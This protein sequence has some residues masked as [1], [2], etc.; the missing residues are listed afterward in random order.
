MRRLSMFVCLLVLI[1]LCAQSFG[2]NAGLT[3][4]PHPAPAQPADAL[5]PIPHPILSN[6]NVRR[7]IYHCTNKD[8]LIAAAYPTL[9]PA[10]RAALLLDSF[11]PPDS[12]YYYSSTWQYPFSP[13]AGKALLDSAG[14]TLPAGSTYR[15]N[16]AGEMLAIFLH[17]TNIDI[18][19]AYVD[20]LR[21]QL[22]ACGILL[23]P[24][25]YADGTWLFGAT[26]GIQR[27]DF[28]IAGFAWV[29]ETDPAGLTGLYGCDSIPGLENNWDPDKQNIMGWCNPT[30]SA[31]LVSASDTGLPLATRQAYYATV[32]D[33]FAKDVP[34]IPLF[35]RNDSPNSWEHLDLNLQVVPPT[36]KPLSDLRVRQAIAHCTNK[37]ALVQ[38]IYPYLT[39]DQANNLVM[40]SFISNNHW[41]YNPAITR[42]AYNP[43]SGMTLLDAA[44]WTLP[45][46]ATYRVN[47]VGEELVIK[48]TTTDS[49]FRQTWGN[50][51][52]NQMQACGIRI[53]PQ[54]TYSRWWFGKTGLMRRNFDLGAFAWVGSSDPGG[55][56]LYD[57]T[58]I[59]SASNGWV[60][61]NYSGWCNPE[62]SLALR[63]AVNSVD[64]ASRVTNYGIVQ[65]QYARDV[66]IIHLFK[67]LELYATDPN[68]SGFQ[69][70][71]GENYYTKQIENWLAP[72]QSLITIGMT[73][74]PPTLFNRVDST[75]AGRLITILQQS[76]PLTNYNFDNQALLLNQV[77]SIANG[78]ARL[79]IVSVQ[80]GDRVQNTSGSVV[81]LANGVIVQDSNGAIV[82]FSG[83][84]INMLQLVV[85]YPFKTGLRWSDN[86]PV[87]R[88]DYELAY[89]VDC[90]PAT[91]ASS[92]YYCDRIK[93]VSFADD[94]SGF[95]ITQVPGFQ[96][97][98]F[99]EPLFTYYPAHRVVQSGPYAGQTLA[100]VPSAA[101]P[102]LPE[103]ASN[104]L[105]AGPY[106]ITGWVHGN[107]MTFERNPYYVNGLPLTE[108][109]VVKFIASGQV[110]TSI[111]SGTVDLVGPESLY[112]ISTTLAQ[113]VQNNQVKV[114]T[115][116]SMTWEH[117]DINLDALPVT[118]EVTPS[119]PAQI[120][121]QDNQNKPLTVNV[122][123]GAVTDPIQLELSLSPYPAQNAPSGLK[124]AGASLTL[125][126]YQGGLPISNFTFAK[127]VRLTIHYSDSDVYR[128]DEDA[129][130][131]DF[132]NGSSWQN[133]AATCTGGDY[134]FQV[135]KVNN[136]L[137]VNIC[138][139]S[140]FAL[141][142]PL[143]LF[144]VYLP[145]T[146][147]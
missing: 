5:S 33:E 82:T 37:T 112:S 41:A 147:R 8:A 23:M 105:S 95:T 44:G 118:Q 103:I 26:T 59:P 146:R 90:D 17:T 141:L 143:K 38:A 139:L 39:T 20:A 18:R 113:A 66:P 70:Q 56:G 80:A 116:P 99:T 72:G 122:P 32:Q 131:F 57:C 3:A 97:P 74:E 104:P 94:N 43:S 27:R 9:T 135:D 142:S 125:T 145:L 128:L 2:V 77:P 73:Q 6:L 140:D 65:D 120:S 75:M 58:Y 55:L 85:R 46:G 110:E 62:A 16:A 123:Q 50:V 119:S 126:A 87:V 36:R 98:T 42:Y 92:Y 69:P 91:G 84:P 132:W 93:T 48:L 12:P 7:A 136:I 30:A 124:F 61:Q 47:A 127:P 28:E 106:Q 96:N 121:I 76:A 22:L 52:A 144:P 24:V 109:V 78:L 100:Q 51:F 21:T 40:D 68:L 111:I 79:E 13:D 14:W 115:K 63:S 134:F 129:L 29:Y 89:R 1:S 10:E 108:Q 35:R 71:E 31:A 133:A 11:L 60:G 53:I 49:S 34:S 86:Q 54:Y 25:H 130:Q 138:H 4:Q 15:V 83:A 67:M 81:T 88:A 45:L 107:S 19:R 64:R 101:W 102:T 114:Y 137:E 117:I